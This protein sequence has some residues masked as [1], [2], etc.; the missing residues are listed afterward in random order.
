MTLS[1][2]LCNRVQSSASG[3]CPVAYEVNF[4]TPIFP[5][6]KKKLL[7]LPVL[8]I[9]PVPCPHTSEPAPPPCSATHHWLLLLVDHLLPGLKASWGRGSWLPHATLYPQYRAHVWQIEVIWEISVE[10]TNGW[11]LP[12]L[13]RISHFCITKIAFSWP[14]YVGTWLIPSPCNLYHCGIIMKAGLRPSAVRYLLVRRPQ[15]VQ[16]AGSLSSAKSCS[17]DLLGA[18]STLYMESSLGNDRT[19]FQISILVNIR[20]PELS[21]CMAKHRISSEWCLLCH[22][23]RGSVRGWLE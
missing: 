17:S 22:S 10:W 11:V 7:N 14:I 9:L 23:E 4:N 6:K 13:N 2:R 15:T 19:I 5:E 20:T 8:Y 1:C 3:I 18:L 12:R 21:K 16:A